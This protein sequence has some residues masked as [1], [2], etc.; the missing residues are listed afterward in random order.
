MDWVRVDVDVLHS[1]C[2]MQVKVKL[3]KSFCICFYNIGLWENFYVYCP[4]K[5][6]SAYVKCIKILFGFHKYSSVT[7]ML[8][9]LGLPSFNTVLHSARISFANNL[10]LLDNSVV[11][12]SCR[13]WYDC[14]HAVFL[15]LCMFPG[16]FSFF[17]LCFCFV[18]VFFLFYG[19]SWLDSNKE[20]KKESNPQSLSYGSDTL[21]RGWRRQCWK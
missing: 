11:S 17:S 2:S 4:N 14:L 7:N 20:R 16:F 10:H 13:L 3:F 18:C 12:V 8:L 1:R 19:S 9:Q 15:Y 6:A 5:F 21:P